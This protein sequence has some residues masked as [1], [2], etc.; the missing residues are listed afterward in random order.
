MAK[1]V[2]TVIGALKKGVRDP[3]YLLQGND[4]YLQQLVIKQ[5]A[6]TMFGDGRRDKTVL[7]PD[8]MNGREI[9][10]RLTNTDLFS[11]KRLFVLRDP[12]QIRQPYR[13][14]LLNYC[15]HPIESH[16][17]VI[18][19]EDYSDRRAMV[20]A[21]SKRLEKVS[22]QSPFISE[23]KKWANYFFKERGLRVDP[24]VVNAV[25][26]IAGDSV[27]HIANEVEKIGIQLNEGEE[28]TADQVYQFSGWKRERQ[29]WEFLI[30][31]GNKD[32]NQAV[33]LGRAIIT[34]NESMLSLIYP[35]TNLFQELLL[36]KIS[37]GTL[38]NQGSYIPLSPSV[39]RRIPQFVKRYTREEIEQALI[40]LGEI[41][42][43]IKSTNAIDESEITKFLFSTLISHG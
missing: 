34:Q 30:A 15:E 2:K 28:L 20:K 13:D 36:N 43:R 10:A 4:Q 33:R 7:H 32:L 12:H 41:D 24:S 31:V 42:K 37:T 25:V 18:I 17:L 40:E 35:L 21:L 29:R 23:M 22:V 16:C 1:D 14:E 3:V 11:S 5:I 6:I 38:K 9:L 39:R 8:E 27:Y 19:V 26:D